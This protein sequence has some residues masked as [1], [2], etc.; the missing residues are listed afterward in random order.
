M[1][2]R[3]FKILGSLIAILCMCLSSNLTNAAEVASGSPEVAQKAKNYVLGTDY[4]IRA[5][6]KTAKPEIR[7]FFSFWCGHC[8]SLSEPFD[9]VARHFAD[10]AEFI[11]NPVGI[12]GGEMG[13]ESQRAYVIAKNH[14]LEQ[15]FYNELMKRIHLDD[16]IPQEHEDLVKMFESLGIEESKFNQEFNSFP[17]QGQQSEYEKLCEKYKLEAVPEL[18]VNGKY[19][20]HMEKLDTVQDLIDIISFLLTQP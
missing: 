5:E 11:R 12:L 19:Y 13:A 4:E 10:Q 8:F 2:Y 6:E 9:M 20:I 16:A 15:E 18:M 7:E 1:K 3:K 14:G 17:V